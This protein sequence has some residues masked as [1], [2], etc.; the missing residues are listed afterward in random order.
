MELLRLGQSI[1]LTELQSLTLM[2]AKRQEK[3]SKATQ[4]RW[5]VKGN[6]LQ[7]LFSSVQQGWKTVTCD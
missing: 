5:Q 4:P 6:K 3:G 1:E 7:S 2:M